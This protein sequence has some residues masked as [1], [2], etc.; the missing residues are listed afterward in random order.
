MNSSVG[1]DEI[2]DKLSKY[3]LARKIV[4]S[5]WEYLIQSLVEDSEYYRNANISSLGLPERKLIDIDQN[6]WELSPNNREFNIKLLKKA[7][8]EIANKS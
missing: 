5:N 2:R 8:E 1:S 6:T 3:K 4:G 7:L